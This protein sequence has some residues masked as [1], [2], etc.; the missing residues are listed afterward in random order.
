MEKISALEKLLHE[1]LA[2]GAFER[3]A[4][5]QEES[6]WESMNLNERTLL[7]ILFITQG[8][9]QLRNGN[10]Q[11]LES[12]SRAMKVAPKNAIVLFRLAMAYAT[13]NSNVRCLTTACNLLKEAVEIESDLC[14]A[15]SNWGC[16]LMRM[17]VLQGDSQLCVEADQ[18]FSSAEKCMHKLNQVKGAEL[19]WQWGLCLFIMARLSG[20]AYDFQAALEKYRIAAEKGVRDA[21]FWNDYGNA[22][23]ELAILIGRGELFLEAI[24]LYRNAVKISPDFV[25]GWYHL[26]CSCQRI[27]EFT[28][29]EVY[30]NFANECFSKVAELN[31]NHVGLWLNWGQ[32]LIEN[33]KV[34]HDVDQMHA[35]LEKFGRANACEPDHPFILG[36]WAEAQMLYGACTERIDLLRE[37]EER[38]I[39]SLEIHP[40]DPSAW[41]IYGTCL[42]EL[43]RY[44]EDEKYY[45]QAIEKFRY[46]LTLNDGHPLLWY[47]LALAHYALGEMRYE[48]QAIEQ[49]L[50][51]CT[52]VH[53]HGGYLFPQFWNDWGVAFME[54][55]EMTHDQSAIESAIEK[56]EKALDRKGISTEKR[57]PDPEW[58]YNYGCALDY[59]G[60][61]TGDSQ[62]HE[63]AIVELSL[64]VQQD[65][66]Y[67]EARY[68]LARAL[69]HLGSLTDDVECFRKSI[70][71]YS[72]LV[73]QDNED[74]DVWGEWGLTLINLVQLI[75]DETDP[76]ETNK[77]YELAE[78]KLTHAIALG[79]ITSFYQLACLYSLMGNFTAAMHFIE[80]SEIAGSL[81]SVDDIMHDDWLEGLRQTNDFRNFISLLTKRQPQE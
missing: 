35:S 45:E 40:D 9:K 63:K 75:D 21:E 69:S 74:E 29:D 30:F 60:T 17:A 78:E 62:A 36:K 79:S 48:L 55:A 68:S 8:E 12:F 70:E 37:A 41:C 53:Q 3:L 81:P 76:S 27:F 5:F 31:P 10:S 14:E 58:I 33:G 38:I 26:G 65:S 59:L 71:H 34:R 4:P 2:V 67:T 16:I 6:R 80:R 44:F 13:Q 24:E 56:F 51:C 23:S 47:G 66:S 54:L 57:V 15:W 61:L 73:T 1:I 52:K 43:G 19:Y 72:V 42:T 39:H 18:K 28:K 46:G 22:I 7:A 25:E 11:A 49:C 20:E 77:L 64:L 32:L 50:S